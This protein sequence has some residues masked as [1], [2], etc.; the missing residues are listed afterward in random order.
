MMLYPNGVLPTGMHNAKAPVCAAP[1]H[2]RTISALRSLT[3][4]LLFLVALALSV[5]SALHAQ[6]QNGTITG[7]VTDPASSVVPGADVTLTQTATNLVLHGQT[8]TEGLY[9]FPQML[10]GQYMIAVEKDGFRK[11]VST[12]TLTVGQTARLDVTLPV[13]SKTETVTIEAE[14][15]TTLDTQTS[16]LDYTVQS[17]QVN[18]LPLNGRNPY[19]LAILSPGINP[20]GNFGVGVTVTRGA[21]VAAATNNFESNGGVGGSNEVLLD[22]VSIVVCCQGQPAVTPSTEVVS[23]FK[24]VTSNAPAEYGRTS[25]AVLNIATKSG[26]NHLHGRCV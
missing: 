4:A 21:V 22:G 13:G 14:D 24:V 10:P 26:T 23:Q 17:Q 18:D 7:T 9:I 11:T 1:S 25:G 6:V 5:P 8:N 2:P 3:G 16:N 15:A 12:L 19:G 20:G